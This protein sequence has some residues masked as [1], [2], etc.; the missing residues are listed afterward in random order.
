LV[1]ELKVMPGHKAKL[2]GF[3]TV[4]DELYP[5]QKVVDQVKAYAGQTGSQI[6]KKRLN[7]AN[8]TRSH[9]GPQKTIIQQ[10]ELLDENTKQSF[11]QHF[12]IA[13]EQE[14]Q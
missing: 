7:S 8:R 14:K 4:I 9:L 2:A 1:N 3:F 13:L 6:H 10:Y 5:R 12:L 11:N